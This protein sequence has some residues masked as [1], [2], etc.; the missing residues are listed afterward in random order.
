MGRL[1]ISFCLAIC[2]TLS[3]IAS[4]SD[5][6]ICEGVEVHSVDMTLAGIKPAMLDW[7]WDN[8]DT[9][10]RYSAWSPNTHQFFEWVQ[11]PTQPNHLDYSVGA[12]YRAINQ[13]AN[14]DMS[15][16]VT[17]LEP[18]FIN[19]T[20]EYDHSILSRLEFEGY[21]SGSNSGYLV[22][23][24][25]A[26]ESGDNLL[27]RSTF[28][29][30][31]EITYKYSGLAEWYAQYLQQAMFNLTRFL[32]DLF[33]SEFVE[34]ELLTRGEYKVTLINL[35]QKKVVVNQE[36][37]GITP[38]MLDWW[39]DNI[40]TTQRYKQWHPTAHVKFKWRKPPE[41]PDQLQYSVGAVQFVSEYLGKYKSNLL[42]TWL[43]PAKAKDKVQYDHWLYAKTDLSAV[44][45]IFPQRMI[46]EYTLNSEGDG[47]LMRST[48]TIPSFLDIV[49]PGFTRE[50][51]KHAQQEM[52][53]LQYFL[54][55][56]FTAEYVTKQ[57]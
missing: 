23:Q 25:T 40:N 52:Q 6:P 3:Q 35:L 51:G 26:D 19:T 33:Q 41:N 7:W 53:F 55:E 4:A 22:H 12:S 42:I 31:P 46:H 43:D 34:G 50:L 1:L 37:K 20:S 47:I 17:R 30:P 15:L 11:Q 8:I 38:D 14:V 18:G 24:Y 45:G 27:L 56:L 32:P 16:L 9:T 2:L 44:R 21:E 36:I 13:I 54:P 29:F 39:W 49:M 57:P 48:F 28:C 5:S 10:E